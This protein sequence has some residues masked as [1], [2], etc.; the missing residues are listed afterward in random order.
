[1]API[2][3][4]TPSTLRL[5]QQKLEEDGDQWES[6]GIPAGDLGVECDR[7]VWLAFRRASTPE[8]IDWRKRRIFQ[9]GEIEEERL[10]DLLRLAGVE[11][12]G[13]QDRVRAAGGHLR[14]KIDGRALG[15]LEAPAKEHVVECKSAKQEVFR[16]VAKEG[17]KLGKPE[18]YATFQFYMY[19]LGID[20]VL[21]LMSNKNDEDI[22]Y[23]RV[24]YDAEFAMRLV[25]RAERLISMPTPPGRLCTKRD[26]FR[27]QFCRQ[28][29]V[30]WGEE[31]PRVHCRSCIHSTPLM[32]G[33]AGWDCARWS[34]P[35]SLDEQDEGCAAHL[36]V[37]EMLVGYE[38]VDAD[39]AAETITYRTPSGDLWTDGAPQQEAA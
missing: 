32:H 39:E 25:A 8:G 24:P 33:N 13:Q 23:E 28:A 22:H 27:G 14:G 26:D 35:L 1:M 5:I 19:G 37:P 30:C 21:Y 29:A 31:R 38:Q 17:V 9:R 12:W 7:A 2:P 11:V 15:L 4:P 36:F 20:R 16:K 3:K 6:V 18:H 10:L 34:K